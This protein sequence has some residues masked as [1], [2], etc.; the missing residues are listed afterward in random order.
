MMTHRHPSETF[1]NWAPAFAGVV[2]GLGWRGVY[3]AT[4][5]RALFTHA[6]GSPVWVPAFAGK[7]YW[8][9][10]APAASC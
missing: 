5:L 2:P 4:S 10:P 7:Q 9:A 8:G 1:P 3:S 6:G